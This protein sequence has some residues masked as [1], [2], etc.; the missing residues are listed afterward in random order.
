MAR[1]NRSH[2]R[3]V[4]TAAVVGVLVCAAATVTSA[5]A[6]HA[7]PPGHTA[8]AGTA[9]PD[10]AQPQGPFGVRAYGL[11]RDMAQ[12][13]DYQPKVRLGDVKAQGATDAVG[14]LSGLRGEITMLDGRFVV[15]YGDSCAACPP[16]HEEKATLLATG[17]VA[18]WA[19]PVVVPESLAG[20]ALE[21]FIVARAQAAGLDISLPFPVRLKGT[22]TDVAMHVLKAPNAKFTGHGSAHP[23]AAL[24][25]IKAASIAGE[26]I[27]FFAP[28]ALAGVISH[29]GEPFHFHW[30][31]EARSKTA[32]I[33]AFGMAKGALL[34]LPKP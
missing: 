24:D 8:P 23:M 34:S 9:A 31:D 12:G 33:D 5:Q 18:E 28:P 7:R 14:A 2:H 3:P 32:H 6:Q 16:A 26:V 21:R 11:F 1:V 13:K 19:A 25:E 29:P 22:L 15:S 30:V 27:G 20:K 4:V 10:A 17:K